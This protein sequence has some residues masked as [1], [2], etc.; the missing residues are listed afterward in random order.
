MSLTAGKRIL[1]ELNVLPEKIKKIFKASDK[2]KRIALS[3]KKYDNMFYFARKYN[4]PIAYEGALKLKEIAYI[5]AEGLG[6]GELKHGPLALIDK[7][8]P[9][10]VIAPD[11]SVY[12]KILN[13]VEEI[14]ARKGRVLA[15]VT[16]GDKKIAALAD[17]VIFIPK[18]LEML[19]P[20]LSVV[21]LHMLAY[22]IGVARGC[23]VDKSRN[24]VK[25]VTVE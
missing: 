12:A 5:H 7:N 23:D 8:F 9:S 11:D 25:S 22:H 13:N 14:K 6:S 16:E 1:E 17:D 10:I 15:V 20:I 19:T 18:T 21:P 4:T 24:L 3:Y 2:I